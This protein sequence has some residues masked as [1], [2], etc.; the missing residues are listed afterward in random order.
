L[1]RLHLVWLYDG[2]LNKVL[3]AATWLDMT[4]ELRK[5]G[6]QVTLV[7][8]GPSGP[9]CIRGIEV[10][11]IPRPEKYLLR[12][13][14]YHMRFLGFLQRQMKNVDIILF[15]PMSAPWLLP[16]RLSRG[17]TGRRR[18]LLVMDI[19]SLHMP[20]RSKQGWKG[21]LREIFQEYINRS[22]SHWTDGYLTITQRMAEAANIPLHKLWGEW[23]SGVD[24]DL[25]A[26]AKAARCWP[27][28]EQPVHLVYMGALHPER[29][30][31]T[32]CQ[33]VE[34]ANA[35]G[36]AFTLLLLG[37]GTERADLERVAKCSKG[38]ISIVTPVP[39]EQVPEILAWAH[40]GVLPFPDEEKFRVSSPIKLF[41]YM[42]AGLPILATRIVCHTAVIGNG[43]Y[44]FWAKHDDLS[45][46]MDALRLTW[47]NKGML[48]QMGAE[49]A[50]AAQAW[51]WYESAT[52]LK[53]ALEKGIGIN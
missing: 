44:A 2:S 15:H 3:D 51:T 40:L 8:A 14:V 27:S 18:P 17:F 47:Q 5:L 4:N 35:E 32:F 39:H 28:P 36:M 52:K 41:E 33:A 23:P 49:A 20:L 13:I 45:G 38:K 1:S 12:Q 48:S 19:R 53:T 50:L 21:R 34:K 30:L 26:P 43:T 29:N 6:W 42:A 10:F 46:L 11:C 37:D 16:V 24:P 25:F 7:S 9:Q 31:M 22:A